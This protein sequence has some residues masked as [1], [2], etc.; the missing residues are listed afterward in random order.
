MCVYFLLCYDT[1]CYGFP[2]ELVKIVRD[3]EE[4]DKFS[5]I[6]VQTFQSQRLKSQ[7]R[8]L[9][10]RQIALRRFKARGSASKLGSVVTLDQNTVVSGRGGTSAVPSR[11]SNQRS[12]TDCVIVR[13]RFDVAVII[14][15]AELS[16]GQLPSTDPR[17]ERCCYVHQGD[18]EHS[19][20]FTGARRVV[21]IHICVYIYIYIYIYTCIY[22]MC[23]SR[24]PPVT[25]T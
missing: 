22:Y 6:Q 20:Y 4:C 13:R 17:G 18:I 1:V 15:Q 16:F 21:Y 7:N 11:E 24:L 5:Q 10:Q 25:T 8:G 12:P 23:R 14:R 3:S 9:S 19:L 2:N